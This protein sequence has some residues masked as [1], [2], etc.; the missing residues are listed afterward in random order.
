[1]GSMGILMVIDDGVYV[2]M[3]TVY[4]YVFKEVTQHAFVYDSHFQQKRRMNDV[5]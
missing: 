3:C 5:V 1:M 4:S 2:C